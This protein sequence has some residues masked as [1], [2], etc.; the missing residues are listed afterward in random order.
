MMLHVPHVVQEQFT[1]AHRP[2]F[3]RT[4]IR[5]PSFRHSCQHYVQLPPAVLEVTAQFVFSVG[6]LRH[7]DLVVEFTET[8]R[9][10][11]TESGFVFRGEI[12]V[13][14]EKH[15]KRQVTKRAS[16]LP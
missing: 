11:R 7:Y 15:M 10:W 2:I 1:I 5:N 9:C 13:E 14:A 8:E 16:P 6:G 4:G 12:Q 3:E